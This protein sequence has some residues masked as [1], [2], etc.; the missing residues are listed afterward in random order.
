[1]ETGEKPGPGDMLELGANKEGD[2]FWADVY[3]G[4]QGFVVYGHSPWQDGQVRVNSDIAIGIDTACVFGGRLTAYVIEVIEDGSEITEVVQV[5]A[6]K[7]YAEP[8][9][10]D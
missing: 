5:S 2:P 4:S 6:L 10:E 8:M 1:M 7:Q 3:D 9:K